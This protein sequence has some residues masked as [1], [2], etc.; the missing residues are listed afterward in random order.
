MAEMDALNMGAMV[1]LSGFRGTLLEWSLAN[2]KKHQARRFLV[3]V[4]LDFERS[5]RRFAQNALAQLTEGVKQGAAGLKVYKGLG[6]T[7][8]DKTVKRI[9]ST[10]RA[11]RRSG[12]SAASWASGP[13][14]LWQPS[15]FWQPNDKFNE[16]W[17][18][19]E[20]GA[21]SLPSRRSLPAL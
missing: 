7:D 10:I 9:A 14:S 16:R 21:G 5:T 2:V 15:P 1:S 12:T 17:L 18:E 3:F 4:N 11:W 6:L 20:A 13:D 19:L 8:K